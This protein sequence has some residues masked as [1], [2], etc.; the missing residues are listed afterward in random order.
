M[1]GSKLRERRDCNRGRW[2]AGP[3]TLG[4]R[5][6][7][8]YAAAV[9][10]A[11]TILLVAVCQKTDPLVA[12][13]SSVDSGRPDEDWTVDL[14]A[15]GKCAVHGPLPGVGKYQTNNL[16]YQLETRIQSVRQLLPGLREGASRVTLISFKTNGTEYLM[17]TALYKS[18]ARTGNTNLLR[19]EL[20]RVR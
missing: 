11:M 12:E 4:H 7:R 13:Y 3:Q 20:R 18:F 2:W 19:Y 8:W 14:Y 6:L 16:G 1:V 15:S 17:D 5:A 10:V 9:V